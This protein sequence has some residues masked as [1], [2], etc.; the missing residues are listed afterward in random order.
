[1]PC[2]AGETALDA[3]S[4][5]FVVVVVVYRLKFKEQQQQQQ[6]VHV[7]WMDA[8]DRVSGVSEK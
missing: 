8:L 4:V 7:R 3:E 6:Q 1:V 2:E 5:F